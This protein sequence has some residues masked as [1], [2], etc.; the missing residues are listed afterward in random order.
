MA[1]RYGY[2][3][4]VK[5]ALGITGGYHDALLT[6]YISE[7]IEYMLGAGVPASAFTENKVVGVIS[8]G[9]SDLW[10]YGQGNASLSPYFAQ[11]VIQLATEG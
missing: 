2:L 4:D 7:V 9:V 11:R 8:R 1:D 10:N 6:I 5:V 3:E